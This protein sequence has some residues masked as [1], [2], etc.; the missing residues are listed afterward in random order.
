MRPFL[1][2]IIQTYNNA[3]TLPLVLISAE[4][5]LEQRGWSYE[6]LVADRDSSDA[7]PEIIRRFE[8]LMPGIKSLEVPPNATSGIA[9]KSA[10]TAAR[11]NWRAII[12]AE[13]TAHIDEFEKA[14]HRLQNGSDIAVGEHYGLQLYQKFYRILHN[15]IVSP[16]TPKIC[17]I[18]DKASEKLLPHTGG[19]GDKWLPEM[20]KL[21]KQRGLKIK[22]FPV[23][24]NL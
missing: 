12:S 18:S 22:K 5:Y 16:A 19:T 11:G 14:L 2:V 21:S 17:V 13:N 4:R 10:L 3:R 15:L 6:I 1:S 9:I 8:L 7:T 23:C 20:L 24:Y